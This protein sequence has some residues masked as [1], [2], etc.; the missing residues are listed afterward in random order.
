[1]IDTIS[2]KR[3][4]PRAIMIAE[5][6][7]QADCLPYLLAEMAC[8]HDGHIQRALQMV[9]DAAD[10]GFDGIQFQLFST[11]TLL[12][13]RHRFYDKVKKLEIS[14]ADWEGIFEAARKRDLNIFVNPLSIDALA[15]IKHLGADA[16][17]VHSADLS[18]PEMLTSLAEFGLPVSLAVGGS[19]TAEIRHALELLSSSGVSD[20]IIMHGFQ[21]YPTAINDTNLNCIPHLTEHFGVHVGYQDHIDGDDEL[22]FILPAN[23]MAMGAVLLEKHITDDRARRGT[24]FE[25]AVDRVGQARF[26][27]VIRDA[28]CARGAFKKDVQS[29]AELRYRETFKKSL[30][31][32]RDI[33]IGET[34]DA[35]MIVFMR[36]DV[37]GLTPSDLSS[38]IGKKTSKPISKYS[39]IQVDDIFQ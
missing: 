33:A 25:S 7:I 9:N 29:G 34:L 20:V 21:G 38:V 10:A 23:A 31:A 14:Y 30:V 18:N 15:E 12:T 17:K 19:T 8:A 6:R 39:V 24:D 28:H 27:R 35:K 36:G 5:K 37:L 22:G 2:F 13:P 16:L 32:V 11:E 4:Y 1:M 3:T 26:V